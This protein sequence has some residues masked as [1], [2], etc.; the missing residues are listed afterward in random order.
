MNRIKKLLPYLMVNIICFYLLTLLMKD[1]GS[2]MFILLFVIPVIT[3]VNAIMC[4]K[5][6]SFDILYP[7]LVMV[8]FVPYVLIYMNESATIYIF[9]YG[10]ISLMGCFVGSRLR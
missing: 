7:L 4:G 6:N 5:K 8:I 9:I 10:V 2:A 3:F 1:T